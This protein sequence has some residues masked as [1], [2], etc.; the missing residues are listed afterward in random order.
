MITGA[1]PLPLQH[2]S[3]RV[4]WHDSGWDGTVCKRPRENTSCLILKGVA[5]RKDD[6]AEEGCAGC[7]WKDL[8]EGKLPVISETPVLVDFIPGATA[9]KGR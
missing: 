5:D 6:A 9:P 8:D 3:I 7:K 2:L 1:R 4:P